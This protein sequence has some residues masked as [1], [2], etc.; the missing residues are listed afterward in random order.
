MDHEFAD[1][2]YPA[3]ED[4]SI[5]TTETG[6][7][8]IIGGHK[9]P[10]CPKCN[11]S[12]ILSTWKYI[13]SCRNNRCS[14]ITISTK[15]LRARWFRCAHYAGFPT[16]RYCRLGM[17]HPGDHC[18]ETAIDGVLEVQEHNDFDQTP[19]RIIPKATRISVNYNFAKLHWPFWKAIAIMG[20]YG[21]EK[22]DKGQE[23][24]NYQISKLTGEKS[25]INHLS[26]HLLEYTLGNKHPL[27]DSRWHLVAI[28]FNAMIEFF[29][30]EKEGPVEAYSVCPT[31]ETP[32]PNSTFCVNADC[33]W[34]NM[35]APQTVKPI[36][37]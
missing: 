34:F 25:A 33:L 15:D 20:H 31:C 21:T 9:V 27:G 37:L 12:M 13:W 35:A 6:W 30:Y 26:N 23:T 3:K 36:E 19:N 22:Y 17:N 7:Y 10:R 2:R 8:S 1:I 4:I 11:C 28:A 32:H 5:K 14:L 18:L 24:P 29:W 16:L